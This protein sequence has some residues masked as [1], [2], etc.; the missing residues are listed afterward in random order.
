[1]KCGELRMVEKIT[2]SIINLENKTSKNSTKLKDSINKVE[3]YGS[4]N[5][6][7]IKIEHKNVINDLASSVP[8]DND[9]VS[10][11]KKAISSGN[12]PLDLDKIS[13]AL[14]EAYNEM[15]S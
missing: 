4:K 8:I 15:K 12:Y 9:K 10:S 7:D 6:T 2:N 11:I 1:M 3:N 14:M 13:D 5:S